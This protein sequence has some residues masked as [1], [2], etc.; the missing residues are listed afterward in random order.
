MQ[1]KKGDQTRSTNGA[2]SLQTFSLRMCLVIITLSLMLIVPIRSK[3]QD[4]QVL[5]IGTGGRTG[6]YYPIGRLIARGLTDNRTVA[7]SAGSGENGVPGHIAVAQNSAGSV[8]NVEKVAS[9]ELEAGMTQADVAFWAIRKD[10]IFQG[11]DKVGGIRAIASLYPE[12]LQIIVRRDADVRTVS[13]LREKRISIDEI[14]SGTLAAMRIVLAANGMTE[15][16]LHPV[17]LKPVFT[18][19]KIVS[20]ELQGFAAMAGTP[21]D[22]VNQLL[23]V[24]ISLVPIA[25]KV[26]AGIQARFPYLVPGRIAAGTYA[27]VPETAT[28]QVYALLVVNET[29]PE[30][31]AYGI[32]AALWSQRTIS[33]LK[34]GHPQGAAITP[35]TA[36]AGMSIPLHPGAEKYY[37]ENGER[38]SIFREK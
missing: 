2:W 32:T 3:A 13:D 28:L 10:H 36:L 5:R 7:S 25:P 22:A 17:Y 8:E 35:E 37:R 34:A 29:L 30:A 9:G 18:H 1:Q 21:M 20:G 26:A 15:N 11:N 16:D 24:G 6:V 14:G 19:E 12:K 33:L 31:L 4:L 27:G 23:G 38:F